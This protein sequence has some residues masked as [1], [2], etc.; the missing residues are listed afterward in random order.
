MNRE[1][2]DQLLSPADAAKLLGLTPAGVVG[3][4]DRGVLPC[5]RTV[6]GRRLFHR[7]DVLK[8]VT[9][10]RQRRSIDHTTP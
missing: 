5:V 4:A 10:R 1:V 2:P 6:G 3:L 9:E 8:L 7:S